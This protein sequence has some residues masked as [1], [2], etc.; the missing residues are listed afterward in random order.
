MVRHRMCSSFNCF[1]DDF[2]LRIYADTLLICTADYSNLF[3]LKKIQVDFSTR[4]GVYIV[5]L[6]MQTV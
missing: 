3:I 1:L 5:E 2:Y 4:W 6:R